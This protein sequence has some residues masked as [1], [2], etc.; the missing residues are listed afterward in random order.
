MVGIYIDG[1]CKQL[2]IATSESTRLT[3]DSAGGSPTMHTS[4]TNGP[5]QHFLR[6]RVREFDDLDH[7]KVQHVC[8][9]FELSAHQTS[10]AC[11]PKLSGVIRGCE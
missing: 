9:P 8:R 6:R 10:Y 1:F 3:T 11:L 7:T 5:T 4:S 2:N